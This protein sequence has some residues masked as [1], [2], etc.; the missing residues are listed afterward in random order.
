L[1]WEMSSTSWFEWFIPPCFCVSCRAMREREDWLV[2]A[3]VIPVV[4]ILFAG[5]FKPM[6]E[7]ILWP[8]RESYA[9]M[10][11]VVLSENG[12]ALMAAAAVLETLTE[13]PEYRDYFKGCS[14]PA[15][16][17]GVTVYARHGIYYVTPNQRFERC[18]GGRFR[19]LDWWEVYAVLPT[20]E[21][22]GR[23]SYGY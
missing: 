14:T 22:L 12:E 2:R 17:L 9:A 7:Y 21:V 13:D 15:A 8:H 10:E 18:G 20:G 1:V 19:V 23:R 6:P 4:V 16:G 5:C 3:R 11:P